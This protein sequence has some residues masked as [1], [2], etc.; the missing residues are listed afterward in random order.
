MAPGQARPCMGEDCS[1]LLSSEA[2][3]PMACANTAHCR[4][5]TCSSQAGNCMDKRRLMD[6]NHPG[7]LAG[8]PQNPV[9]P[10]TEPIHGTC[11]SA[12]ESPCPG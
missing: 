4:D 7:A 8:I 9:C 5:L 3:Q 2:S 12:H 10:A 1:S 6:S 11:E